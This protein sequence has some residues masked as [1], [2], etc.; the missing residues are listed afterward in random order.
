MLIL[1]MLS[2]PCNELS[3]GHCG[4]NQ[5][6]IYIIISIQNFLLLL[7]IIISKNR[8]FR[9]TFFH[10]GFSTIIDLI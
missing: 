3:Q 7:F 9:L 8:Q 10:S 4:D 6:R 5:E 2:V 1:W